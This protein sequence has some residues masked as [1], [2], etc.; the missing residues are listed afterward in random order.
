MNTHPLGVFCVFPKNRLMLVFVLRKQRGCESC[1]HMSEAQPH[2][3]GSQWVSG[4]DGAEE[5]NRYGAGHWYKLSTLIISR[6]PFPTSEKWH[7]Y[8]H[9]SDGEV[10]LR[11]GKYLD[12]DVN[13]LHGRREIK[14]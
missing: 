9:F 14:I 10:I 6:T 4:A 7:N 13:V 2:R 12:K 11:S 5:R 1:L 8:P 3:R